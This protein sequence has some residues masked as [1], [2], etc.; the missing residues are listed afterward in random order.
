MRDY[1][2]YFNLYDFE[3]EKDINELLAIINLFEL[4][5]IPLKSSIT[6][7]Q[8]SEFL[9]LGRYE[10]FNLE[11]LKT[12][13]R[14]LNKKEYHEIKL[15]FLGIMLASVIKLAAKEGVA[16]Y[17]SSVD[18]DRIELILNDNDHNYITYSTSKY[19][20]NEI[21]DKIKTIRKTKN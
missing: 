10:N 1:A 19:I 16:L 6:V 17:I 14:P 13:K 20:T 4:E 7:E 15:S 5:D 9:N 8:D 3:N 21:K 11:I 2:K 18:D 12:G